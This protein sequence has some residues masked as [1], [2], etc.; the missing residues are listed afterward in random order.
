MALIEGCRHELEIT[1]PADDV[2]KEIE[3]VAQSIQK[4]AH[5]PGFRPGK[6]PLSLIRRHFVGN[7]R[8]EVL[9]NLLGKFFRERA[10]A[11]Q[12]Q[13]VGTPNV[14]EI[15]WEKETD[16][17]VFKAQFD[18]APV[19]EL[20]EYKGIVVSYESPEVT[21]AELEERLEQIRQQRA[22]YINLDP[23]PAQPGDVAV[24]DLE[25]VAGLEGKPITAQAMQ[26]ELGAPDTL[27]AFSEGI[28]GMSPGEEK[29]IQVVYPEDYAEDRLA[30]KTVRF[31][32]K[33][34][35]IQ[36]KEL[37]ELNDEFAKDLG[38]FQNLEELKNT[39][40]ANLLREKETVAQRAAKQA[41]MDRLVEMH[42]FPV[43]ETYIDRQVDIYIEQFLA[44]KAPRGFDPSQLDRK[45]IKE[46]MRDRAVREVKA[47]L[48]IDRIAEREAIYTTQ[49]EI[50]RE[51]QRYAK[52][53]REVA[54][55][56][57]RRWQEDGTLARIASAIRS[58]KTL[59]F[60][61]EHARKQAPS[62]AE[63]PA[64]AS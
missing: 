36:K 44:D 5:L 23:R 15:R 28:P 55:A 52:Q 4:K 56:V 40:R 42:D 43:P 33:L 13:V 39:V 10:E 7:I 30:G 14:S 35:L 45:K 63:T 64:S 58:E 19:I 11:E 27:A 2:Q 21:D 22:E 17:I 20:K 26:V 57:R 12:L 60:L 59:N 61:F 51:V 41:I 46:A 29:V 3:R 32:V 38:D 6:A 54:A 47:T 37:P 50:D 53:E 48:L 8:Q 49:E 31:R 62:Q 1:I 16:P 25:S 24:I 34:R 18:V 9:D